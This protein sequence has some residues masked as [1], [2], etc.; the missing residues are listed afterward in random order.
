MCACR[1]RLLI[2]QL[3]R[4]S[5]GA[6]TARP[7]H[8]VQELFGQQQLAVGAVEDVEEAVAIGVQHQFARLALPGRVHQHGGLGGIPIPQIV[9]GELVMPLELAGF[10]VERQD[11]VGIQIIAG[12][13]IAVVLLA[14][15]AGGPVDGIELGVVAAG[16]PRGSAAVGDLRALPRFRAR[17]AAL[18]HHL[19]APHLFA[20]RLFERHHLSVRAVLA[21]AH[22]R[23]DVI[24]CSQRSARG[25][26][27]LRHAGDRRIPNLFAREAIERH[28]V[29]VVAL[30]KY[31]VARH[32][33]AA[34]RPARSMTAGVRARVK[35]HTMRPLPASS[36]MTSFTLV[37][38]IRP[39]TTTG[40][41]CK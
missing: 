37:T 29:C 40:V 3:Y 28:D 39:P 34:I 21:A 27:V 9:R 30:Q 11:A 19:E 32:C 41:I 18:G 10:A 25:E 31:P 14:R 4:T 33:D 6:D 15:I 38:Y 35:R 20:R 16:E 23:D 24:A 36:A 1:A 22:A 17:V 12:A 7:G 8:M 2:G 26:I 13:R 5:I